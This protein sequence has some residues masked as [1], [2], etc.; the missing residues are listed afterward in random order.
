[1]HI[2]KLVKVDSNNDPTNPNI[3]YLGDILYAKERFIATS[4]L[5]KYIKI[6]TFGY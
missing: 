4:L 1:M 6:F 2:G 3:I 5:K